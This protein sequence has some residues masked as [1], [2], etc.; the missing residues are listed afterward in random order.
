MVAL[1]YLLFY[2]TYKCTFQMSKELMYVTFACSLTIETTSSSL[3]GSI[4]ICVKV[5]TIPKTSFAP[6]K[7]TRLGQ[8]SLPSEPQRVYM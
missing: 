5:G 7:T 1:D 6:S 4:E 8:M 2:E 3:V